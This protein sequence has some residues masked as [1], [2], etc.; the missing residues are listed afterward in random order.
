MDQQQSNQSKSKKAPFGARALVMLYGAGI[1]MLGVHPIEQEY[2]NFWHFV[3]VKILG[4]EFNLKNDIDDISSKLPRKEIAKKR[5]E[6]SEKKIS[7]VS[8]KIAELKNFKLPSRNQD[9][10][11]GNERVGEE[12][13]AGSSR[14]LARLSWPSESGQKIEEPG[15]F[16][17]LFSSSDKAEDRAKQSREK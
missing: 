13:N 12:D 17:G 6:D 14:N 5:R 8:Q 11:I 9:E 1:V 15:F 10:R 4:H 2:G 16:D 3:E 7:W